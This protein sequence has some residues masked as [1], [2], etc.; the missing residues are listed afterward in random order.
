MKLRNNSFIGTLNLIKSNPQQILK[1]I[2]FDILFLISVKVLYELI[3]VLIPKDLTGKTQTMVI[4][5][6]GIIILY[7][8][9]FLFVYSFCK[10]KILKTIKQLF[11]KKKINKYT[12]LKQFFSL[13]LV[14]YVMFFIIF[15]LINALVVVSAK[16]GIQQVLFIITN[17]P[18]LLLFYS[19]MNI[20][21]TTFSESKKL[22][23]GQNI[24]SSFII[25]KKF[26]KYFKLFLMNLA[27]IIVYFIF[28]ALFGLLL[29]ITIFSSSEMV[30]KY[31]DIY[32]T[33]FVIITTLFFYLIVLF[34][35]IYF[36][37]TVKNVST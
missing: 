34:N 31:N 26:G 25:M 22:K 1:I 4:T 12:S 14:I 7:Y 3:T 33:A 28:Y 29:K 37:K 15:I 9:A 36:Y 6:L 2:M 8:L 30:V 20:S 11:E 17:V 16:Q 23:L 5:Y 27:A 24:K 18:M 10:R 19:F 21:H 32:V 13:N 35:R